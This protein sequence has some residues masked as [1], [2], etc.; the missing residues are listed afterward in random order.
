MGSFMKCNFFKWQD[1]WLQST[2]GKASLVKLGT[3]TTTSDMRPAAR[4]DENVHPQGSVKGL[5]STTAPRTPD[6]QRKLNFAETTKDKRSSHEK[7]Q[8][9]LEEAMRTVL[10]P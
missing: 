9:M 4:V 8:A 10:F 2:E 5:A 7:E 6:P 3:S 1:E